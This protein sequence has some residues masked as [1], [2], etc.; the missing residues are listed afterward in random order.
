MNKQSKDYR[1][2]KKIGQFF[3]EEKLAEKIVEIFNLDFSNKTIIEHSCGD[4]VFV[5]QILKQ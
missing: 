3:T 2:R 5:K 1:N 4:G